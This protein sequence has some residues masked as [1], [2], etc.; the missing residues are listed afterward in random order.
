MEAV[1]TLKA[2]LKLEGKPCGWCDAGLVL[3]DDAAVCTA[4]DKEH[5]RECWDTKAGCSTRGC[6]SAPLRRLDA[7]AAAG[8]P[9]SPFAAGVAS[10]APAAP[11][12]ASGMMACPRCQLALASGTLL[13]PG[14]RAITS[15]DGLYHGPKINA[16]GAV[17]SLV[18]GIVGLFVCGVILGPLAISQANKAKQAMASD[19]RY[20]GEG[21][22]TA[23]TVLG[24]IAI[25]GF[26]VVM[27][28]R[29]TTLMSSVNN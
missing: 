6:P 8:G 9:A 19:P 26:V 12:L 20:G 22:A 24:I 2:N 10:G 7:A 21:L 14:C 1:R 27:L 5:H 16:P 13:C 29:M 11:A 17:K 15:P 3:G 18:L 25:V 4:C 28:T 23:G